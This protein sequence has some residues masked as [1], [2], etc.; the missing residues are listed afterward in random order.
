MS[1]SSSIKILASLG[2]SFRQTTAFRK[3]T[4]TSIIIKTIYVSNIRLTSCKKYLTIIVVAYVLGT[5]EHLRNRPM[6]I[7]TLQWPPIHQHELLWLYQSHSQM[8][9]AKNWYVLKH[10]TPQCDIIVMPSG[11]RTR[12]ESSKICT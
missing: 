12:F 2:L 9:L 10:I 6:F 4:T 5:L 7:V 8:H 1:V 11:I 3:Y